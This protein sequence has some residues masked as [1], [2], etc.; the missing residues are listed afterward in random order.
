MA[1][2]IAAPPAPTNHQELVAWVDEIAELTQPDQVVWCDGSE[3]EYE[4][5]AE[6]LVARGTF[7]KLDPIKRPNSYYAASDPS[8]V[9][10]VEDRTFICSVKEED[11]GPTNHWKD[12]AEMREIFAGEQ[13]IFRGS[14]RGRTMYVVPFCMGPVG[15]PL[16]AI[17][18]EITDSAYVAVAM[19][20]MTRMG[21]QVLD[22]LGSDGFFVKAV[23]TL[24]APLA[25]G[26]QDVP[27]PCNTTKY[28]SHFPEDREIWSYGS[29]YGGNA[30]L[31]KKCYALRIASVMAR[32]EG[33]L[34]E[35]MLILKLTPPRGEARYVAAAFPS[36]C[37]KTNLA[38]LEPAISGWTVET[39]GDDIAWMRFGEDGRLY[40]INPEAGFFGV[41]PGTGEHTNA[42]A[43]KTMWG[44]SVF[45]NV[46]LTD[47]GD[48]WWE[49]MT[50]EPPAHLTDWKGNDWTPESA[51]PAAHPNARFTVPAGQCPIIAPEW[52]DPKGVPI[53]AILF[54]GRRATA[55]P[56]VT[57]SLSWNHGVFLGANV[58]SE[59]TAAAEGKV[60]ELRRD[61]F[62][63]LPFCG[64]NMGDYMAHWV[65]VGADKDQA[66]LPKIYYVNWFRKNDAGKF[67]W[68]GFGENSRVLKWIVERLDGTA[69]GVETPIGVLP[70]K[71]SLDTEGLEISDA[72][73]DFLLTVDKGAWREEAA[74]VPDHFNTFGDH[75]P[76]ELWDEHR[77]LVERL[78]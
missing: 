20:T 62:A 11:A 31:G 50:E 67:V 30:L 59:K 2:D 14:M 1:R 13:G 7:T 68:P 65:K 54:G 21:Q 44:N 53:S 76:K 71:E 33:W 49:G 37:G 5:L 8:D 78:G 66:K 56:L 10:R 6:E 15:S 74:L 27:W 69:E 57:E 16:S 32:D 73:L 29:G 55:V 38:M 46:A 51:T 22:E 45:T 72:D 48:V 40:A 63:M 34:A 17:G 19:R 36:A 61:P 12:P 60:G 75:T 4:R 42:N 35:H 23:H 64:Y 24:G 25:E 47:D 52:E 70:T 41:A 58:A 39:I 18:V 43:M 28:I 77:A 9:A 3:A 26:E